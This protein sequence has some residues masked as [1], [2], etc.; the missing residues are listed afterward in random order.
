M[1]F[2][3]EYE[4]CN[5][6]DTIINKY[7]SKVD[8]VYKSLECGVCYLDASKDPVSMTCRAQHIYCF[9]CM[10]QYF[11]CKVGN[12]DTI[13]CPHCRHGNG[14]LIVH[15]K[16]A[17]VMSPLGYF[18]MVKPSSSD[19]M[20][21]KDNESVN[22]VIPNSN[23]YF[24]SLP[25]LSRRFP[26]TFRLSENSCVITTEQMLYFVNNHTILKALREY[27]GM[28]GEPEPEVTW[29]NLKNQIIPTRLCSPL[30]G[31]EDIDDPDIP[32]RPRRRRSIYRSSRTGGTNIRPRAYATSNLPVFPDVTR[33]APNLNLSPV[34]P[35]SNST[36]DS[37]SFVNDA[38][39]FMT[40][41][42]ELRQNAETERREQTQSSSSN[43]SSRRQH[44]RYN[45]RGLGGGSDAPNVPSFRDL[46][47]MDVSAIHGIVA[48]VSMDSNNNGDVSED[49]DN[50]NGD[51]ER[52]YAY[53]CVI[54]SNAS[55]V[56]GFRLSRSLSSALS[57]M[58]TR[59]TGVYD[60]ELL[61]IN[62]TQDVRTNE[63]PS[64]HNLNAYRNVIRGNDRN[65]SYFSVEFE[66][67]H[68]PVVITKVS[69]MVEHIL[70]EYDANR[71]DPV[72]CKEI[73][74]PM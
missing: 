3:Y 17:S 43:P 26:R 32:E 28:S 6:V 53:L 13:S 39:Q 19:T 12:M 65:N 38:V 33:D 31:V 1:E 71:L 57:F 2:K 30:V 60:I 58:S 68:S 52:Q 74:V 34:T 29:R 48:G 44:P 51:I 56:S 22:K 10:F 49:D 73:M 5:D 8:E 14:C 72:Y 11:K 7:S 40:V 64:V 21:P 42:T 62:L 67:K 50:D 41:L 18:N 54:F 61:E 66:Q 37:A 69:Q 70:Y 24:M 27:D 25:D 16:M 46:G 20:E 35:T 63:Q 59:R 15:G 23:E 45:F 47:I 55:T 9:S 4:V 36:D